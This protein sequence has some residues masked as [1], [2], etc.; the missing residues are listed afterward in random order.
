MK[1]NIGII[2]GTGIYDP[3]MFQNTRTTKISIPYGEPSDYYY[4]GD[5]KGKKVAFLPRHGKNHKI[6]PHDINFKANISG[7]E[8]LGVTRVL[9]SCATGSL[10]E[11]YKPGDIVIID[12]FIDW[13]K[14]RVTF[15]D[16]G[17]VTH[18]S[19]ADPFCPELRKVLIEACEK[20]GIVYHKKGTYLCVEG[21]R[22]STRAESKMFKHF[23]ELIGMTG[24]PEA[25]LAR[26]KEICFAI[27]ATITDYDVWTKKPVDVKEVVR[28]M[29][30][31]ED[32][33]KLLLKEAIKNIPE[34]RNCFCK[35]ALKNAKV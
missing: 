27:I 24:V 23:A 19:L 25:I 7:F 18:V 32:K 4:I 21:P 30:E 2:G 14:T 29:K 35:N 31:S 33:V 6:P 12:Q 22:F 28:V 13:K 8:K 1:A 9:A 26:E 16:T 20:L 34:E 15:Y 10:N 17:D 3:G 5:F 11:K